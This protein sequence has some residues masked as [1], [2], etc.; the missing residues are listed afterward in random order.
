ML[1]RIESV[2]FIKV[3]VTYF[4]VTHAN[5]HLIC[6]ILPAG[7]PVGLKNVG[8]TCW[9]S[10]VIQSLFQ[11]PAFRNLVL[12]FK[13]PNQGKPDVTAGSSQVSIRGYSMRSL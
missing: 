7:R 11:L 6:A 8:N 5:V 10:A 2:Y 13:L 3:R 4:P 9:F 1:M 12:N